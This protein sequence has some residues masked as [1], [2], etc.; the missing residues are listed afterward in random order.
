MF[1]KLSRLP[2]FRISFLVH[3]EKV[4]LPSVAKSAKPSGACLC[5]RYMLSEGQPESIAFPVRFRGGRDGTSYKGDRIKKNNR[6]FF[7]KVGTNRHKTLD[8]DNSAILK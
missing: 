8:F 2:F 7:G 4:Y 3:Y 6:S 1:S 5:E